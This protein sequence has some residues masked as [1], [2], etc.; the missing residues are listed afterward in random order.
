M[1]K[2]S[3]KPML[4]SA[5]SLMDEIRIETGRAEPDIDELQKRNRQLYK[6]CEELTV[7]VQILVKYLPHYHL[8]QEEIQDIL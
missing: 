1:P 7:I 6:R 5:K 3:R 4:A 8:V 2:K